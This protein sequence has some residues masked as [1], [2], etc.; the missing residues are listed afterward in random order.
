MYE[1]HPLHSPACQKYHRFL[2]LNT[3]KHNFLE[4]KNLSTL[5]YQSY[6]KLR[7][8]TMSNI[9]LVVFQVDHW[10]HPEVFIFCLAKSQAYLYQSNLHHQV[11]WVLQLSKKYMQHGSR[12]LELLQRRHQCFCNS[13]C[14]HELFVYQLS[15]VCLKVSEQTRHYNWI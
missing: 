5:V 8:S 11:F 3:S 9:H 2:D 10:N 6:S 14:S 4:L 15:Q 13:R 12:L 7:E 1:K